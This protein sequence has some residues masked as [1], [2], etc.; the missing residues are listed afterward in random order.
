MRIVAPVVDF[1]MRK[2]A[3]IQRPQRL[4]HEGLFRS[5]ALY[6]KKTAVI[7]EGKETSYAEF[8]EMVRGLAAYLQGQGVERGD[9]CVVFMDNTLEC[10]VSVYAIL[11]VGAAFVIVNPQTKQDKLSYILE[12]CGAGALITDIHLHR[13]FSPLVTRVATLKCVLVSGDISGYQHLDVASF[14]AVIRKPAGALHCDAIQKDLSALI[15]TSGSTGEPKGVMHTHLSM[16]FALGS[17]IEYLRLCTEDRILL[18]L[19]LA[20]D[21]GLYQLL[22]SMQLGATLVMERSFTYPAIVFQRIREHKVT[23]F[24]GVPTIFS[25]LISMHRR[26]PLVFP[27]IVRVTNT[28]AALPVEHISV[29]KEIFPQALIYTMYGLTECK[30]V[31]YLEPELIDVKPS[32][33]GKAIPGTEVFILNEQGERVKPGELGML[34]VRGTHIMLGYWNAPE[35]TQKVLL[36]S[37]LPGEKILCTG[38]WFK[39]DKDG[40]LYFQGR[41]DDVIKTRGEKVSPVEVENVVASVAGVRE[42]AVVG[43]EDE[44]LG[45]AIKCFVAKEQGVVLSVKEVRKACVEKLENFMVPKYIEFVDSLPKTDTGKI[46]KKGLV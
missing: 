39:M 4:L 36:D 43:V 7:A 17:L 19:P 24:P 13:V 46:S 32:S 10:A 41:S 11:A 2:N 27:G 38:D 1:P 34:Y 21:Y 37:V 22:M 23:V 45:E 18:V 33:V 15:Y 8:E 12:D 40:D 5:A 6:P 25:L 44:V 14:G 20:F 16:T 3:D 26:E 9:R 42:V 35:H 30:R 29:L 28:A 31:C